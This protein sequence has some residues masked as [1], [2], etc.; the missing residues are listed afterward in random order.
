[1]RGVLSHLASLELVSRLS[2]SFWHKTTGPTILSRDTKP[3]RSHAEERLRGRLFALILQVKVFFS[4]PGARFSK[5]PI[6][7]GPVKLS[8]FT[9]K[10]E[11]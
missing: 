7:N 8:L 11:V 2:L 3:T 4:G 1:M 10:I 5:V 6:I 9:R